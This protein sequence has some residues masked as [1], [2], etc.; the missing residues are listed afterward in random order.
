MQRDDMWPLEPEK[1]KSPETHGLLTLLEREE[2]CRPRI[3]PLTALI[4]MPLTFPVERI[5]NSAGV[6]TRNQRIR[7]A[8]RQTLF[9]TALT[10]RVSS[11]RAHDQS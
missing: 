9:G 1:P 2:R 6:H 4:V 10:S 7:R 3:A 11:A 8:F 5:I